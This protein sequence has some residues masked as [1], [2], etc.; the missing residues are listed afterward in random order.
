MNAEVESE[1][2]A[3]SS[4]SVEESKADGESGTIFDFFKSLTTG[5]LQKE[6]EQDIPFQLFISGQRRQKLLDSMMAT[7]PA[8]RKEGQRILNNYKKQLNERIIRFKSAVKEQTECT[9]DH[10]RHTTTRTASDNRGQNSDKP[11]IL[12]YLDDF[13]GENCAQFEI[14]IPDPNILRAILNRKG[15]F[16]EELKSDL[17]K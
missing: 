2:A 4:N 9:S 7:D 5:K 11:N 15:K 1:A 17:L 3:A 8:K 10:M 14:D 16:D 6:D 13:L 12:D